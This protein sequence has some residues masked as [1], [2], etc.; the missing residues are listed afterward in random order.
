M[1]MFLNSP[2]PFEA[3]KAAK[4]GVYFVDKSDLLYYI[5][6]NVDGSIMVM[7]RIASKKDGNAEHASIIRIITLSAILPK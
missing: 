2:V 7:I 1:G 5:K 6:D 3:Y 4:A